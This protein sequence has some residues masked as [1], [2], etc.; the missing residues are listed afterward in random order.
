MRSV[1][2]LLGLLVLTVAFGLA[3]RRAPSAFPAVVA[4]YGGDALW[5]VMVV[6]LVALGSR[7]ASTPR[8]AIGALI[9][10][11]AVE[12]S[13]LYHAPW[14]DALRATSLGALVLGYG[15]LWSDIAAY[16]AGVAC[17]ALIDATVLTRFR[18]RPT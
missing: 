15:F 1:P 3:T 5:A 10:C 9:V 17:A 2:V 7:T 14:I 6:W 4:T 8:I 16:T 13:Q 18:A 11:V 12:C